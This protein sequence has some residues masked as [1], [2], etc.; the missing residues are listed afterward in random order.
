MPLPAARE[1]T[2][3]SLRSRR[4][5]SL[6]SVCLSACLSTPQRDG[7][8][9]KRRRKSP[10]PV[11]R[12]WKF[13]SQAL[14]SERCVS[15]PERY[16]T[17]SA[18]HARASSPCGGAV[19]IFGWPSFQWKVLGRDFRP[20]QL[21]GGGGQVVARAQAKAGPAAKGVCVRVCVRGRDIRCLLCAWTGL[22][23]GHGQV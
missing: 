13:S 18:S 16:S 17:R 20:Q 23:A 7:K 2:V 11:T 4:T 12:R 8:K 9:K 6:S 22:G 19:D 5:R 3:V 21:D 15:S 10:N 1:S 14:A